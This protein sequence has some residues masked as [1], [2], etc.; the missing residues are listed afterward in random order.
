MNAAVEVETRKPAGYCPAAE[1]P[2]LVVDLD[3]TLVKTDL[4]LET[5]LLLLKQAPWRI[6]SLP[7]WLAR[8]R[9]YFKHE[10]ARRVTL[11]VTCL[12][13]RAELLDYLKAQRAQ[14][15]TLVLATSAD[16]AIAQP[17]ADHLKLFDAVLSSDG[18]TNLSGEAKRALLVTEY[19]ERGFDYVGNGPDDLPVWMSARQGIAAADGRHLLSKIARI[20]QV[21]RAFD[22]RRTGEGRRTGI[23][24]RLKV[25]RP[26]HWM[27]NVLIFVPLLAAHRTNEFALLGKSLVGFLA[28]GLV[29]SSGY[30]M[31]DLL[32]LQSDRHHPHKRLRAFA[33]GDLP[34]TYA[35]LTIP[36]LFG[37]GS[38]VAKLVSDMFLAAVWT[39]FAMTLIYSLYVRRIVILDVIFLASLYTLR[40]LAGSAAVLIWPSHWLLALST[41]LFFSMALVK[42]YGELAVMK[43]I[44]GDGATARAYEL[45]DAELLAAMGVASGYLGVLVLALYINSDK[46]QVLYGRYQL[47]WFLCPLLL[48]WISHV[49]LIAHRGRMPDDPVTFALHD[50]TS[51]ILVALIVAI[52]VLAL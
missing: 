49:W 32:D 47:M 40:L 46:A 34:L 35:L 44:D 24:D 1:P 42:R 26:Q 25:L 3:G 28:F 41:F 45:S 9:A 13:Y 19:G 11:D 7:F 12:P 5:V 14:G 8:G 52:S 51:W 33:A 17:V 20:P 21:S 39:Y 2:P 15:R 29:A 30:L 22:G 43:R 37:L 27:K 23:I 38:V 18:A 10:V 48:Y 50:R 36:V 4:L 6:L 31:N 16:K